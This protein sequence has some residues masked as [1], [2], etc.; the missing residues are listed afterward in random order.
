VSTPCSALLPQAATAEAKK[1]SDTAVEA[2]ALLG[3]SCAISARGEVRL[4]PSTKVRPT[5]FPCAEEA[6][7]GRTSEPGPRLAPLVRAD[8][9]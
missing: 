6:T 4:A 5:P 2:A 7:R 9:L 1:A 8:K 3:L